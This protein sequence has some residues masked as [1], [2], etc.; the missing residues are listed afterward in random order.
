MI[1]GLAHAAKGLI[2]VEQFVGIKQAKGEV[3]QVFPPRPGQGAGGG[4]FLSSG[5]AIEQQLVA[6]A[7]L[8]IGIQ[9]SL[10]HPRGEVLGGLTDEIG[11]Q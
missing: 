10:G 1:R 2:H 6:A 7:D 8:F 4:K 5:L 11:I 3:G 9:C